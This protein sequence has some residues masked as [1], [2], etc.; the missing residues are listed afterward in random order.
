MR[1]SLRSKPKI[2]TAFSLLLRKGFFFCYGIAFDL[3]VGLAHP[4]INLKPN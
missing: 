4:K 2:D 1:Q 3:K